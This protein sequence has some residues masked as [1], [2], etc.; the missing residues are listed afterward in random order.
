M[1]IFYAKM[2]AKHPHYYPT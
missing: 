1:F 2:T